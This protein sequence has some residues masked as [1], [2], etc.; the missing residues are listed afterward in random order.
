MAS[1]PQFSLVQ[2]TALPAHRANRVC[3][4]C[5][6]ARQPS[7]HAPAWQC[8]RCQV[9]Y[10]KHMPGSTA[11]RA[12]LGYVYE[13]GLGE[14]QDLAHAANWYAKAA[15]QG[16]ST[17][18][19]SL[20]M[21]YAGGAQGFEKDPVRAYL[22]LDLAQRMY[23]NQREQQTVASEVPVD[24]K[25]AAWVGGTLQSLEKNM[26]PVQLVKAKA[27]AADWRPGQALPVP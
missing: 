10:D 25:S 12:H 17:G 26:S 27:L 6:Y 1:D 23:Q 4:A 8:P 14:P 5:S 21:L 18:L 20:G 7:D 9:V 11:E 16:N 22:L 13:T 2:D 19:Y 3:A 15:R 24:G